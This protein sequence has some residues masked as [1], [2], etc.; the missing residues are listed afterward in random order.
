VSD[1]LVQQGVNMSIQPL[2]DFILVTKQPEEEKVGLIYKPATSESKIVRG[3]VM[4][5]GSGRVASDGTVVPLEVKVGDT[6]AFNRNFATELNDTGE[7]ALIIR[8]D[9]LLAIIR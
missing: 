8:E 4:A 7:S 2:R 3:T 1:I 6:V 9:Q 5:V